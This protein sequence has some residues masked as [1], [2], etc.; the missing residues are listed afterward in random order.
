L[1]QILPAAAGYFILYGFH[2]CAS[3]RKNGNR[4]KWESTALP[5]AKTLTA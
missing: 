2:F 1:R 3:E 4:R 5:K